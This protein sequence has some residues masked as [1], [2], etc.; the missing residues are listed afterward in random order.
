VCRREEV[1][2]GFTRGSEI[3]TALRPIWLVLFGMQNRTLGPYLPAYNG[4]YEDLPPDFY[5]D[6]EAKL[7]ECAFDAVAR[8][9]RGVLTP[10]NRKVG[11]A[12]KR[13]LQV[14]F[15]APITS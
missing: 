9:R 13:L 10:P 11:R 2:V 15:L 3:C 7:E 8:A 1:S 5:D 12:L 6:L 14:L 4:R